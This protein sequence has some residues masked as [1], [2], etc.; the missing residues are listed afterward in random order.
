[1]SR[2]KF[3]CIKTLVAGAVMA[4]GL[5]AQAA[6]LTFNL[7]WSGA[8]QGNTAQATAVLVVDDSMLPNPGSTGG[9]GASALF[10]ELGIVRFDL[11]VTGASSGN[12]SFSITDF[13]SVAW[14]TGDQPLDLTQELVGQDN[15]Q[16]PWGSQG[17]MGGDF[18]VFA[19]DPAPSG[20]NFFVLTTN[21]GMGD[22]MV[23]TN[24]TPVPIGATLPL[25][26]SA[27]GALGV[28]GGRRS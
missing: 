8:S 10:S 6:L 21:G 7:G 9:N 24:F 28:F 4:T 5:Q 11:V 26:L 25:A 13:V 23:L 1:M 16:F 20:T 18:N 3:Y 22:D 14:D 27:L 19:L 17:G 2:L 12:G 15:G